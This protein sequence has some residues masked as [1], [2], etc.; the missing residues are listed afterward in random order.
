VEPN[1]LKKTNPIG[2][3][4]ALKLDDGRVVINSPLIADYVDGRFPE[5][6]SFRPI[7]RRGWRLSGGR[8]SPTARWTR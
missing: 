8:R 5:R 3:V 6:V 1:E 2:K 7:R 4:P